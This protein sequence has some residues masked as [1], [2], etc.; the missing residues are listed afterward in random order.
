MP[1]HNAEPWQG[2]I[3]NGPENCP[4]IG[5]CRS[6]DPSLECLMLILLDHVFAS[7]RLDTGFRLAQ[8]AKCARQVLWPRAQNEACRGCGSRLEGGVF[9]GTYI[10]KCRN[11]LCVYVLLLA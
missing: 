1:G 5:V 10:R 9:N 6:P 2:S 11:I 7:A 3:L 4:A 8:P